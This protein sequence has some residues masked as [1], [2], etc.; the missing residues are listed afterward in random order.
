V[1]VVFLWSKRTTAWSAKLLFH[2]LSTA[3]RAGDTGFRGTDSFRLEMLTVVRRAGLGCRFL[4][5][6]DVDAKL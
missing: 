6:V 5:R 4:I 3:R 1:G 2:V